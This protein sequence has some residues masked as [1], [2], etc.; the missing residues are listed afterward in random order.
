MSRI[1]ILAPP[2]LL[3][4]CGTLDRNMKQWVGQHQDELIATWGPPTNTATL[5]DGRQSLVYV[6]QDANTEFGLKCYGTCR[7]VFSTDKAGVV[8]SFNYSGC[9]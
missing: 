7:K 5:S 6:T 9:C 3:A 2:F 4:A 1:L 8:K